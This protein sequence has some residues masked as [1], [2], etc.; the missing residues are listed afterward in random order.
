MEF[1]PILQVAATILASLGGASAIILTV[2]GWLGKVWAQ[3]LMDKERFQHSQDLE[4]LRASLDKTNQTEIEKIKS[5]LS[6][7]K[8]HQTR[9]LHEKIEVYRAA[10]N[11]IAD[12]LADFDIC[13]SNEH[14]MPSDR[15]Y[16]FNRNR[17]KV[18]AYL[19]MIASQS[20]MDAQDRL[21]DYLMQI[22]QNHE[23]H[24]WPKV[25][26]LAIDLLNE[27]RKDLKF[28]VSPIQYNGIL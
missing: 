6:F 19:G 13:L 2:S 20:V 27:M 1:E 28:D 3:R 25:R 21:V 16:E 8:D 9:A 4:E 15:F 24:D 11:I 26:N 18:Y 23:S 14:P 17:M 10:F 5:E 22:A 7:I 12:I